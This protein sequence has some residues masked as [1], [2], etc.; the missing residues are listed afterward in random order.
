MTAEELLQKVGLKLQVIRSGPMKDIGS[1]HREPTPEEKALLE[2][3]V[4]D[5][6]DQFVA[7]VARGR[8]M[9]PEAVRRLADGRIFTGRQALDCGLVDALGGLREAVLMAGRLGGIPGEPPVVSK[10]RRRIRFMDLLHDAAGATFATA[11]SPRLEYR[12]P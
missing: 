6:Y 8:R 4:N 7:A 3:V 12:L 2:G 9:T 1:Y 11:V 5:V 10:A